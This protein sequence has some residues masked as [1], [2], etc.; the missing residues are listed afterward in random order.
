M[1]KKKSDKNWSIKQS[2]EYYGLAQWGSEYF[3]IN[4]K[5][6]L[7]VKPLGQPG[8]SIDFLDV[9]DEIQEKKLSLPCV[10]RFQDILR[11]RVQ[12]LI[13]TFQKYIE[14]YEYKGKYFGVYPIKVNQMREVVEEILDAGEEHHFGLE[15]GSKAELIA[16]LAHNTDPEAL[17]ICNGYKDE[18]YL[19]LA[20]LGRKLGRKVVVVIEK[21]SELSDL[22]NLAKKMKVDPMI[23]IRAR[24]STPGSGKWNSSSG[25]LAKFGL[26]APEMMQMTEIL[27]EE[28]FED[29][30]QLFHFHAGSQLTNIRLIKEALNE[31]CR[32]YCKLKKMGF[33][34]QYF[35]VEQQGIVDQKPNDQELI[36]I[37]KN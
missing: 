20:L 13:T 15:A 35:E 32:Y 6:N 36:E 9:I 31:A 14:E 28:G 30:L 33:P 2:L 7:C 19:R 18:T 12:T 22:L 21:L 8:P 27:K 25:D 26:T 5:G 16:V 37:K 17:T 23:G 4:E 1:V 10:I 3:D 11:S 24:L 34:V 29:S